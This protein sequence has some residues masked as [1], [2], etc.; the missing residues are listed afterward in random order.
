MRPARVLAT[1]N[2]ERHEGEFASDSAGLATDADLE[3]PADGGYRASLS[4]EW[5][6]GS[7]SCSSSVS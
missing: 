5:P 2:V 1:P 4:V 6:N 3:L 7:S